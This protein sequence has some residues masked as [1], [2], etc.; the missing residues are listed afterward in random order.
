MRAHVFV[1]CARRRIP[2]RLRS[3]ISR[4]PATRPCSRRQRADGFHQDEEL[5]F[6]V[7]GAAGV[8]IAVADDGLKRRRDPFLQRIGRLDVV[9]AIEQQRRFAGRAGPFARAPADCR[10]PSISRA[11]SRPA[12][13]S[14]SRTN[15]AARPHVGGVFGER[16]DAGDAK[17]ADEVV[18]VCRT[19]YNIVSRSSMPP[20]LLRLAYMSEFL[21]ALVAVL[22]LWSQVGGQGHL[23]LMP[24][25]T[26]LGLTVG[27]ALV[28]VMGTVSAVAHE[29]AWNAKTI[30]C[31]LLALMLA[32]G[33]GGRDVLLSSARK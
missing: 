29:R 4:S 5:A 2:L 25:Y 17:K 33:D 12:R 23:D 30:A 11:F 14:Q 6:V 19:N 3:G 21:L 31:L 10:L 1:R 26:K 28:T 8:E 32:G 15:S 20:Y 18:H 27:L 13:A 9:M 7:G 24:W 16:A 22:M